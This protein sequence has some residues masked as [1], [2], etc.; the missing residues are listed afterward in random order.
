MSL[1]PRR[2]AA[3]LA[4]RNSEVPAEALRRAGEIIDRVR[5]GGEAALRSLTEEFGERRRVDPLVL[6]RPALRDALDALSRDD[7]ARLARVAERITRFAQAQRAALSDLTIPIPGGTAGHVAVPVES[8]GC[9][10]PG[11]RYP[12]PS[13]AL[14]TAIPAR[15]AGVSRIWLA[16]PRPH[17]M[18]L[19]AAAL[20]DADG[21]L[22]AGGAHAIA[23]LAFGAGPIPAADVVVGPGNVYVTAAKQLVSGRVG[24]DLL[25]GPSELVVLADAAA[26]PGLIAADLLAQAEHDELAVP[27]LVTTS[28][29]LMQKVT[30]E[31]MRQLE[32]LSTAVTAR[33][34]LANGGVVLC[35][36]LDDACRAVDLIA[37][38]HLEL[39]IENPHEVKTRIRHW[40]A[41][42][43]GA[44]AA[45]VL[46]DYGAGPNHTLPTSRAARFTGGLSVFT[47]LRIRSWMAVE[48][49]VLASTLA[50]DAEWFA[51]IEGLEGHARAAARRIPA[52]TG[53]VGEGTL[54]RMS[55]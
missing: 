55:S 17:P 31:L 51:R 24:I 34:A 40:G 11:G 27:V 20:A 1:F 52:S 28:M 50:E 3:E 23:A 33:A 47:F 32:D 21:V 10:V 18:T 13:S 48:D 43:V 8:A 14:M 4:A 15:V 44:G 29:A 36:S 16:T 5:D 6:D 7:R 30:R 42:F 19:A 54:L 37:P 26:D 22:V 53:R 9:Y 25:A 12:L 45:E 46:G 35:E 39:L 49:A 41:A 38:E 2:T